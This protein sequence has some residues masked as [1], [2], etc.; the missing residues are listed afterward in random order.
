MAELSFID[1]SAVRLQRKVT[2]KTMILQGII[3]MRATT[4]GCIVR[5]MNTTGKRIAIA[6]E[7]KGWNQSE[8]A[9]R[10]GVKPQSVQAWE[11]GKNTPRPQKMT[12]ISELLGRTVGYLMGDIEASENGN[13][14]PAIQPSRYYRY[15][16]LSEVAAG[17]WAE[18]I[19]P[20]EP[21]AE[22]HFENT[23]YQAKGPAF[24]LEVTGD[25]MTSP[26]SPSIPEG[27]FVLVD[28]GIEPK[29]GDLVVAKLE[30]DDKATFKRLVSDAGQLYLK[31]LNPAYRMI[32]I[33]RN[34]RLIGVVKEAKLKL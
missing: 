15:P 7:E 26:T 29:P 30:T 17:E 12:V 21:G 8:F 10:L 28:T 23:D 22:D 34:C 31:P 18:A 16:V 5:S 6:R 2:V 13:V 27:A 19:Q 14:S 20:Y 24:W 9:R 32:P 4:A 33:D 1:A 11:S 25:S 3:A